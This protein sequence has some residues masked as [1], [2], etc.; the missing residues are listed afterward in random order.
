VPEEENGTECR[1]TASTDRSSADC[2]SRM[3]ETVNSISDG[4]GMGEG[5]RGEGGMMEWGMVE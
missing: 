5:G 4:E 1:A 2:I 3:P